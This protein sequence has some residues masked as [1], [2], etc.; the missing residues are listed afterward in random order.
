MR[1]IHQIARSARAVLDFREP[2]ER[3]F[4]E[5]LVVEQQSQIAVE[6]R[7]DVVHPMREAAHELILEFGVFD[8]HLKQK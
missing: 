1:A 5:L 3:G 8:L 6:K 4:V 7:E 2:I